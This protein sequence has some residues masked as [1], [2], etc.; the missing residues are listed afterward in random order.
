MT[1]TPHEWDEVDTASLGLERL[2]Q[3]ARYLPIK[4]LCKDARIIDLGCGSGLSAQM[5]LTWGARS[6]IGIDIDETAVNSA[7]L[8]FPQEQLSFHCS[9]IEQFSDLVNLDEIDGVCL[10]ETLQFV[11]EPAL[12]LNTLREKLSPNAWVYIAS[13]NDSWAERTVGGPSTYVLGGAFNCG[14][15]RAARSLL[16]SSG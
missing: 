13:S 10:V 5:L 14:K 15:V 7:K 12:L 9:Y 16:C 1:Q 8:L 11:F 3:L 6:V 2:S 4:G